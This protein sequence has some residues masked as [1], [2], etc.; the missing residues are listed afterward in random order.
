VSRDTT[1][2]SLDQIAWLLGYEGPTSF[3]NAFARWTGRSASAA[4]KEQQRPKVEPG[5]ASALSWHAWA[6]S[7]ALWK[8]YKHRCSTALAE[9][10]F[11]AASRFATWRACRVC[12]LASRPLL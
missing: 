4:R 7:P 5:L 3:N 11:L 6:Q 12:M 10:R 8:L 2:I 9:W 1:K